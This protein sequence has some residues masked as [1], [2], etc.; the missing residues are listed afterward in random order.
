MVRAQEMVRAH[1]ARMHE[2]P[3]H[4]HTRTRMHQHPTHTR[5]RMHAHAHTRTR[6]HAH[7]LAH[8]PWVQRVGGVVYVFSSQRLTMLAGRSC[9]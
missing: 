6:M 1:V 4:T 3:M 2:H 9:L 8:M 7:A 5:T